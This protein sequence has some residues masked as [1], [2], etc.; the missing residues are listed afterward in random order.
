MS[1][2]VKTRNH[3]KDSE[4]TL[5]YK[6]AKIYAYRYSWEEY[7]EKKDKWNIKR[8]FMCHLY[9]EWKKYKSLNIGQCDDG[10]LFTAVSQ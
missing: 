8:K 2:E 7:D 4:E 6:Q 9:R 10:A 5:E 1:E 3:I